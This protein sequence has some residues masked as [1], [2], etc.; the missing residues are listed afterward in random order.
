MK[1]MVGIEIETQPTK[2]ILV[3]GIAIM[4]IVK[5]LCKDK[6]NEVS[7]FFLAQQVFYFQH[8]QIPMT[9]HS[10]ATFCIVCTIFVPIS[11]GKFRAWWSVEATAIAQCKKALPR[12]QL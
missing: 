3:L 7:T 2:P 12:I 6:D 1:N 9:Q 11:I 4:E 5:T 10:L 8:M